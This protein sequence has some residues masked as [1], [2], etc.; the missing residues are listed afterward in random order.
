MRHLFRSC[1][2]WLV[3]SNMF[4]V[5]HNMWDYHSNWLI[6][7]RGAETTNQFWYWLLTATCWR[8]TILFL[9]PIQ[10]PAMS[11]EFGPTVG[12]GA[13]PRFE[14]NEETSAS[15]DKSIW[16]WTMD[17]YLLLYDLSGDEHPW[18][19]YFDVNRRAT[20]FRTIPCWSTM[21]T[22]PWWLGGHIATKQEEHA[23]GL[24]CCSLQHF[25]NIRWMEEIL[26]LSTGASFFQPQ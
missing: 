2:T 25:V 19:G 5:F 20:E 8:K 22:Q 12:W 13:V 1:H 26:H 7:F 6:F 9:S 16:L 21:R 11:F 23:E 3:V 18:T 17:H 24:N 4:F 14:K 15:K 10:W